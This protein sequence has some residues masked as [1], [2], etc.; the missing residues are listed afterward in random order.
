MADWR[1]GLHKASFRGVECLYDGANTDRGRRLSVTEYP[2]RNRPDVEDLGRSARRYHVTLYLLASRLGTSYW[3]QRDRLIEAL[4]ADGAGTLVHP[5]YGSLQVL[6][7]SC[8][9][10]YS[11]REG[12]RVTFE[13]TFV[14]SGEAEEPRASTRTASVLR[15]SGSV[16]DEATARGFIERYSVSGVSGF[17]RDRTRSIVADAASALL[18]ADTVVAQFNTPATLVDTLQSARDALSNL[19]LIPLR[20]IFDFGRDRAPVD[21]STPSMQQVDDNIGAVIA[22]VRGTTLSASLDHISRT[23]FDSVPS[24]TQARDQV[25]DQIDDA[26]KMATDAQFDALRDVRAAL[27]ED[28]R[29]RGAGLPNVR[30]VTPNTTQPALVLAQRLYQ[31]A[32]RAEDIVTRNAVAHPGFVPGGQPLE[33]LT[34]AA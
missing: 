14:E 11:T 18:L 10:R 8:S 25:L 6:V 16:F 9:D 19:G 4:E 1:D 23:V 5:Y 27:V 3:S 28:I 13:C 26:E 24:A 32:A 34:D 29:A 12:G 15:A 33:V 7:E 21:T 30:D 17:V 2:Q 20:G 22:V 31:D